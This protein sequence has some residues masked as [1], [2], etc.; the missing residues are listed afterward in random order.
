MG[1]IL[2]KKSSFLRNY[3]KMTNHI[4]DFIGGERGQW[5]VVEMKTVIGEA[6]EEISHLKII[7]SS[8]QTTNSGVWTLKGL[9]SNIRYAEKQEKEKLVAIQANLGRTT[10][11]HATLI[12]MRKSEAW[13]A[14]AQDERRKIFENQSKHTEIGLHYLPA[15]ARQLYHSRDIGEPF[16]FLT[17]FEYAPEDRDAFHELVAQLR[18]TEEWN[19]VDREVEINL[20]R[21]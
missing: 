6:I 18:K 13:W 21:V 17:W 8:L 20:V 12:P 14:M 7:E 9:K 19:Y 11:T 1:N 4:F 2:P 15:I 10:A 3:H 16:D 5:K